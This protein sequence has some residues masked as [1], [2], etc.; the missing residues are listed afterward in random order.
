MKL[1]TVTELAAWGVTAVRACRLVGYPR[2]SYYRHVRP[3]ARK[4]N[5]I[6][7]AERHQPAALSAAER[8]SVLEIMNRDEYSEF[9][10]CQTFYRA[11]DAGDHVASKSSWY[12]IAREAGQANDRRRQATGKPKKI[13]ELVATGPNQVWSWD[14]TKLRGRVRG[15]WFH[16]YVIIDIFSRRVVG[17]RVEDREDAILAREMI[18]AAVT[19]NGKAPKVFHSDNGTAMVSQP[20]SVLLEK[21]GIG[22]SFSRPKV[23]ND[24]PFSEA[25]FKTFKYDLAFPGS[26]DSLE[27]AEQF[28]QRFFHEYN[29]NH[30]HSGIGWHTP[31]NVHHGKTTAIS[32]ARRRS[33]DSTWKAHPE[34]FIRRPTP[35]TLPG[36]ACINDPLKKNKTTTNLSHTG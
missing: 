15:E 19:A 16:L 7:Q 33:L 25:C 3:A 2:A 5:P 27:N 11:W 17:W 36:R 30:R 1:Q 6:P 35:P 21:L 26:F 12:R 29:T 32:A 31:N 20:V 22:K 14:I 9:S 34:R 10:V 28:C 4:R 8:E 18:A 23:S 24:N 13:P